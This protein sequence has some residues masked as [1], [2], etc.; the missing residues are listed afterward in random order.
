MFLS[1]HEL[2]IYSLVLSEIVMPLYWFANH[3]ET[4]KKKNYCDLN[5]IRDIVFLIHSV[6]SFDMS[7]E[8]A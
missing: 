4:P 3:Q 5:Y 2:L 1:L 7:L 8:T 6:K